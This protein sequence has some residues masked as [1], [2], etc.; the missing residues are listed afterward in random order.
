M[1]R[2]SAGCSTDAEIDRKS[3]G[4]LSSSLRAGMMM[5]SRMAPC[6]L[7]GLQTG[8][9][10]IRRKPT[11]RPT[12]QRSAGK[13]MAFLRPLLDNHSSDVLAAKRD[14]GHTRSWIDAATCEEQVAKTG[15]LLWCFEREVTA[16]ITDDTVDR[17]SIGGIACFDIEWRPKIFDDD[18]FPKISQTHTLE[19]V[20]A[21][22]LESYIVF[23]AVGILRIDGWNVRQNLDVVAAGRRL[24]WIGASGSNEVD[25]RIVRQ[26]LS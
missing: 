23:P 9:L 25:R 18:V 13:I 26:L 16:T 20:Q 24:R 1:T 22:F 2:I 19:F 11:G 15:T 12:A 3:R 17:A 21:D 7:G 10:R 6:V 14:H 8:I 5:E 4:R